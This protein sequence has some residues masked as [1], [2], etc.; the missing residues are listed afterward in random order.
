MICE[1]IHYVHVVCQFVVLLFE[2][3]WT[4][5]TWGNPLLRFHNELLLNGSR[6]SN[7][8]VW[9]N[10]EVWKLIS[11]SDDRVYVKT[12]LSLSFHTSKTLGL[13]PFLA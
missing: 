2:R 4:F 5:G 13:W 6:L 9:G 3:R 10:S 7:E 1:G 11:R 8:L 12:L